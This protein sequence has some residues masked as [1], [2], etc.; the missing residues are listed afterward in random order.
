ME[1]RFLHVQNCF[2]HMGICFFPVQKSFSSGVESHLLAR[3]TA[4]YFFLA[5]GYGFGVSLGY[6]TERENQEYDGRCGQA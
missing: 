1:I 2:L 5:N 6:G 3:D 4:R